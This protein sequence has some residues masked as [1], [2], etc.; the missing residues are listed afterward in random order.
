MIHTA[1]KLIRYYSLKAS[2]G[3]LCNWNSFPDDLV[4]FH[5]SEHF[6][7]L[8]IS[9]LDSALWLLHLFLMLLKILFPKIFVRGNSQP[10]IH[11]LIS[12]WLFWPSPIH[13]THSKIPFLLTPSVYNVYIHL[14]LFYIFICILMYLSLMSSSM[15]TFCDCRDF[16]C[17][18][19]SC[20]LTCSGW[21]LAHSRCSF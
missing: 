3:F 12:K 4:S 6:V 1:S 16:I 18:V 17:L 21:Y 5:I 9:S 2:P 20:I 13:F 19:W 15:C 10:H 8:S 7:T 11:N 14:E